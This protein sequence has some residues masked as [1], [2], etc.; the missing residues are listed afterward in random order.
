MSLI[1]L[2]QQQ[3]GPNGVQEISQQ[4]GADPSTTQRA[5]DAALPMMVGGMAHAA[6]QPG[7]ETAV[8]AALG[9]HGDGGLGSL[10]GLGGALG[11]MLGG[12]GAGSILGSILGQHHDTVQDGVAQESGLDKGKVVQLLILLAPIVLR[13]LSQHKAASHPGGLSAGLQEEAERARVN[14]PSPQVG[15]VLGQ[16]LGRLGG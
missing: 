11:G 6:Q 8:Q 5:I 10:G 12:G 3:L 2:V 1:D 9:A 16:I 4:L 7:G 13:A 14:A 15:G